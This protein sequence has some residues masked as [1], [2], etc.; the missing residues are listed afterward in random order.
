MGI[1]QC[2]KIKFGS[3]GE[4]LMEEIRQVSDMNKLESILQEIEKATSPNDLRRLWS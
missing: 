4:Q 2:L 3:E 1:E